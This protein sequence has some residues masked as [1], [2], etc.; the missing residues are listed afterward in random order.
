MA[1][2]ACKRFLGHY[3][4]PSESVHLQNDTNDPCI[5][6]EHIPRGIMT[7]DRGTVC[8]MLLAVVQLTLSI[9]TLRS[10]GRWV[11]ARDEPRELRF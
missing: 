7:A 8:A 11:E 4:S 1:R 9:A 10:S 5:Q 2:Q 6:I 3:P